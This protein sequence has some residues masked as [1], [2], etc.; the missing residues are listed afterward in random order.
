[1]DRGTQ[2]FALSLLFVV[3]LVLTIQGV[4]EHIGWRTGLGGLLLGAWHTL[5]A[6]LKR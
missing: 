1:M 2:V 6:S 4:T 5:F 3:G